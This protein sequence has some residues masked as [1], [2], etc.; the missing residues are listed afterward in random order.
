MSALRYHKKSL[1]TVIKEYIKFENK[2]YMEVKVLNKGIILLV[3]GFISFS[4]HAQYSNESEVSV[5]VTGGNT[6]VEVYNAKTTNEY[7]MGKNI[8]TLGGHYMYG[9]T[10]DEI[11]SR[12][13]DVNTRY[14]RLFNE[15]FGTFLGVI[16]E[17]DEFA[18]IDNRLNADL[19]GTYHYL[20]TEKMQGRVEAG[21]RY[22][23]EES[24]LG[25]TLS[26]MQGRIYAMIGK[27]KT[28]N[29]EI[30]FWAEYL[31]N[32]TNS[33]DWQLNFAPSFQYNFMTNLALKWSYTGKYDNLPVPGN[34]KFDFQYTTSLIANF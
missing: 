12:N 3:I 13:W 21:A 24:L 32:F 33:T 18:G 11:S 34:K 6:E 17:G 25:N 7:K 5:V 22:R 8:F 4:S 20:K 9:T 26:E 19:G 29:V 2:I 23:R 28:D 14:E 10:S 1:T 27:K 16:Y 31:P 15:T 30:K